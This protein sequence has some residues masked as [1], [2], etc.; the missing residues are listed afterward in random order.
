V[1]K[2]VR[3]DMRTEL[4]GT[5]FGNS[6][7]EQV[8][9]NN[10][11]DAAYLWVWNAR[12]PQG[13]AVDWSFKRVAQATLAVT[14]GVQPT[15]PTDFDSVDWIT[16][17][18]GE[19]VPEFDPQTFDALFA[20]D[21]VAGRRG[22]PQGYKVVNRQVTF[23]PTSGV[24]ASFSMSY[25]RRVTHFNSLDVATFGT[26][27]V[28]SDYPYWPDHHLIV[29]YHAAFLGHAM[30]SNPAAITMQGLRDEALQAMRADLEAEFAP[31]QVWSSG[32]WSGW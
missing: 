27:S 10:W 22:Q 13:V 8:R 1:S 20:A 29:V 32:D 26:F 14:P 19:M 21:A 17:Q 25:T 2:L 11:L 15:M 9:Q 23:G 5:G 12:D 7:A 30:N 28:D 24:T 16:D 31:A 3:S 4:Q 6:A 18:Y